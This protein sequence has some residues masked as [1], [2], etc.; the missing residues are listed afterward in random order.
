LNFR[1]IFSSLTFAIV[2]LGNYLLIQH[3]FYHIPVTLV[4]FCCREVIILGINSAFGC[5]IL[6]F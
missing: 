1:L 2:E 3:L 6:V 4:I 5:T